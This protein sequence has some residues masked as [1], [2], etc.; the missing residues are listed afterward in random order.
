M[1]PDDVPRFRS[2]KAAVTGHV[3]RLLAY[4][5]PLGEENATQRK[6]IEKA[7][8][9]RPLGDDKRGIARS[10]RGL[11]GTWATD[12]TTRRRSSGWPKKS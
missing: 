10:P 4:A 9:A 1:D 8:A 3:G 6:L 2:W 12:R 11:T 7:L 5:C